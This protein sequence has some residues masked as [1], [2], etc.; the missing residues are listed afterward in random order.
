MWNGDVVL[1]QFTLKRQLIPLGCGI[2]IALEYGQVGKCRIKVPW[3]QLQSGEVE[4]AADD[5]EIVLRLHIDDDVLL[6]EPIAAE[7]T[8]LVRIGSSTFMIV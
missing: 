4:I 5:V 7:S 3:A 6:R 8:K 1:T 2:G